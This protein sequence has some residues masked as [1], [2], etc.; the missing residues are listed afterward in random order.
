MFKYILAFVLF[1]P[2]IGIYL[3]EEGAYGIDV[4]MSGYPNGSFNAY[5]IYVIIALIS[6]YYSK[7]LNLIKIRKNI[8]TTTISKISP[9]IIFSFINLFFLLIMLF[10]FGGI[11][12]LL[13]NVAKGEF[14]T[15]F[16]FFGALPFFI[17][18]Y[19]SPVLLGY[20]AFDFK[21]TKSNKLK[22]IFFFINVFLIILIGLTWG[23]KSTS[24]FMLAPAVIIY[25]WKVKWYKVIFIAIFSIVFLVS[26]SI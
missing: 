24:I 17:S 7:K 12:V 1:S 23:F 6:F 19:F 4:G 11:N 13:G 2:L 8:C 9:Y 21:K 3:M 25:Y 22:S 16:G 18:R 10:G 5:L 20:L 15:S 26:T 14:R